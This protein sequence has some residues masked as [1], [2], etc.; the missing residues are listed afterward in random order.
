[1]RINLEN[2]KSPTWWAKHS[3]KIGTYV[4]ILPECSA[5]QV[6]YDKF[7]KEVKNK[8]TILGAI[9]SK[10]KEHETCENLQKASK[11]V[12]KQQQWLC[13]PGW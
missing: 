9:C 7:T 13:P 11:Q 8:M 3:G 5:H 1:M 2:H 4:R 12:T 10:D 6:I